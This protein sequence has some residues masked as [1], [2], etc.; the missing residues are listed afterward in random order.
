[1]TLT[2]TSSD[3]LALDPGKGDL[4]GDA[5]VDRPGQ[6]EVDGHNNGHQHR[7]LLA[8]YLKKLLKNVNLI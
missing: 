6:L 8:G 7:L 1:M 2:L 3:L 5:G 4:L